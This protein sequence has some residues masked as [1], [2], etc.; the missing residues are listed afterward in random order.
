[1]K[2]HFRRNRRKATSV[3]KERGGILQ[4]HAQRSPGRRLKMSLTPDWLRG[5][6]DKPQEQPKVSIVGV[7][8]WIVGIAV[9]ADLLFVAQR[10][11]G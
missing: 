6:P 7:L 3:K 1:M 8:A 2:S 10:Y 9:I 11:I 4:S 5:E